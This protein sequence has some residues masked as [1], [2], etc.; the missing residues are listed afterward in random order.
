M[1]EYCPGN[2]IKKLKE[3]FWNHVMIG[4]DVDNF[5][6]TD[7]FPL[8][9]SKPSVVNLGYEIEIASG[10]KAVTNMIV[11]GSRFELEGHTFIIDLIPF[12]HG[13][14]LSREVEFCIDLIPGAM[15]V[16]KSPYHLAPK[17]L[18]ELSNQLKEL[19]E[20]GFI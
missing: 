18:Q 17:E 7:F 8:I 20:K 15:P 3:E 1:E 13:L 10:L 2:A 14:P 9:N 5:I 12:G 16:A 6:S 4:A 19:Q 11:Q